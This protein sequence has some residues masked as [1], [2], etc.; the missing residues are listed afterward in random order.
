MYLLPLDG[1]FSGRRKGGV[2]KINSFS[3]KRILHVR[4]DDRQEILCLQGNPRHMIRLSLTLP[5]TKLF[6]WT[7]YAAS[8]AGI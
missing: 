3:K 8:N 6:Q 4:C 5:E 7:A 2:V 1:R